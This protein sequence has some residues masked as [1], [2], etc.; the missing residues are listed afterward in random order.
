[1]QQPTPG[2]MGRLHPAPAWRLSRAWEQLCIITDGDLDLS[3]QSMGHLVAG[4]GSFRLSGRI[5]PSLIDQ[6]TLS[7]LA[8]APVIMV[9]ALFL[10]SP[11]MMHGLLP[12]LLPAVGGNGSSPPL[13]DLVIPKM[14]GMK[15]P[16]CQRPT[17]RALTW[18]CH[19][20]ASLACSVCA[21]V[22]CSL[23]TF[24]SSPSLGAPL[25]H[26]QISEGD[27]APLLSLVL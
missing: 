27:E 12:A 23:G 24:R 9:S 17:I 16:M 15:S 19:V 2:H 6:L 4:L 1:M 20:A 7:W 5:P 3:T 18:P 11:Q 25:A 8:R 26:V 21:A 22:G 13:S 10:R 14:A